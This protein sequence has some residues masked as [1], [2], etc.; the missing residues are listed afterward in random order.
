MINI[1]ITGGSGFIGSRLT[2]QLLKYSDIKILSVYHITKPNTFKG[3]YK[4]KF[5][6]V[7][8]DN[9]SEINFKV[10]KNF[11]PHITIHLATKYTHSHNTAEISEIINSNVIFGTK[12]IEIAVKSGCKNFINTSTVWE[13]YKG[14]EV[15]VN[16]YAASKSAFGRIFSYYQS[17]YQLRFITLMLSNT[18]GENDF[19]NKLIPNLIKKYNS[20]INLKF[21]KGDQILDF[22]HIEDVIDIYKLLI[23]K[24]SN[25]KEPY[26]LKYFI[27]GENISLK[28]L[29]KMF[30]NIF[31]PKFKILLDKLDYREREVMKPIK[32]R[33]DFQIDWVKKR[34]LKATLK[35]IRKKL[36]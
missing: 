11:K 27:K 4:K 8:I 35:N 29:L 23:D 15:P 3:L 10:I 1:L 31:D 26:N 13:Y 25:D 12:I 21:S 33:S 32:K 2:E 14:D 34:S 19:R 17:K 36:K 7:K 30:K 24:I 20:N 18:Y 28:N 6:I 9:N 22:T 16:L 5:K